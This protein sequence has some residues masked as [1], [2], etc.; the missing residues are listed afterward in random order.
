MDA[1]LRQ[2]SFSAAFR[3]ARE[4]E[5]DYFLVVSVSENE[6]DV[7]IRGELF[8]GRTGARAAVF[9]A[10]RTG[11]DRLCYASRGIV[12]Q[13]SAALP[14]RAELLVRRQ[15]QGL[16]D[17]GRA[18]GVKDGDEF[19]VILKGRT[20]VLNEGI[21]LS[22]APEDIIGKIVIEKADEEISL[23]RLTRNGFFDRISPGDEILLEPEKRESR[24]P[25]TLLPADPELRAL[26]R[27]L[28]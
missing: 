24:N 4:M 6:R 5:A 17:K 23:G 9:N 14:F 12:E 8:V 19:N 25:G 26:L 11:Q 3:T 7:S 2:P 18:D 22:Y 20:G 13:L 21:G 16:I 15:D 1:E 27:M 28:H 10:F